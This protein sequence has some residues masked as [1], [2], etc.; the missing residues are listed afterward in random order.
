MS[1]TSARGLDVSRKK[2]FVTIAIMLA[3]LLMA[4]ACSATTETAG[5]AAQTALALQA[6]P[7]PGGA[8][9]QSV[10]ERPVG[11]AQPVALERMLADMLGNP[12]STS[13]RGS[14]AGWTVPAD[15]SVATVYKNRGYRPIWV[16]GDGHFTPRG[17]LLI[18]RLADARADALDPAKYRTETIRKAMVQG[19]AVGL[20]AAE[21]MLSEALVRYSG[22]LWDRKGKDIS[23]L[24]RAASVEDFS[25]FLMDMAPADPAYVQLRDALAKY[26]AIVMVG[27]WETIPAGGTLRSGA[28]DSR[29]PALRRRLAFSGDLPEAAG[30]ES[31]YFDGELEKAV[32]R[33]QVRH[34]LAPDGVVGAKSLTVFNV[35]AEVRAEQLAENLRLQRKPESRFGDRA[36]VVNVAAYELVMYDGGKEVFRS[37]TIVGLP[38]WET[39]RLVSELKWLEINPTWSVPQ[40][41]AVEEIMPKLRRDGAE[42]LDKR[43][44]RLFD[45]KWQELDSEEVDLASIKGDVLPFFLRQDPGPRNPLGNVK[46]NFPNSESIYLHDTPSRR[47]FQRTN[48]AISHGCVRVEDAAE[49]AILLLKEEGWTRDKYKEV[50]N[51]GKTYR[52]KLN[53][54]MPI[55]IVTRTAWVDANNSVQFRNDPYAKN[56]KLRVALN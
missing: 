43:G 37:R 50:L 23:L 46:F 4:A 55:H 24:G 40:S 18:G 29:V 17:A 12:G 41:I 26:N 45:A 56:K 38:D 20:S 22:D 39:P 27:G 7:A 44:F 21:L 31:I 51:S 52:V 19:D 42:Y 9:N 33:F 3:V 48:R 16:S 35:P 14:A 25:A 47:L 6:V 49:L 13:Y 8:L 53:N 34:G 11:A 1:G 30:T 36:I 54:S 15:V 10:I 32:K 28:S 5:P 2:P